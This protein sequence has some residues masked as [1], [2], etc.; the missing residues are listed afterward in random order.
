MSLDSLVAVN[1]TAE[2]SVPTK[3][4]F[5]TGLVL[6]S[7]AAGV[8]DVDERVRT[9]TKASELSEDG[10]SVTGPAY[11]MAALYFGQE[12]KPSKLKVASRLLPP[13]PA[14]TLTIGAVAEDEIV[15]VSVNGT[16]CAHTVTSGQTA[17]D[18]A[19]AL[20]V[21]IEAVTG[22]TSSAASNVITVGV[23]AGEQ[24]H[25][26]DY[27]KHI[28]PKYT[29]TDP[30]V[31]T[32][33]GQILALDDD[34]FGLLLDSNSKAEV[35][36]AAAWAETNRKALFFQ[37][38][39][40]DCFTASNTTNVGYALKAASYA[41][42]M[43]FAYEGN[44]DQWLGAAA[45]G[46]RF[47]AKPGSYS[48]K[49]KTLKG[50]TARKLS[51]SKATIAKGYNLNTYTTVGGLNMVA[52]GV[53]ASGEWMDQT[54]FVEWLRVE[55]QYRTFAKMANEEKVPYTDAGVDSLL[56]I[57]NGALFDGVKAGGLEA[58]TTSS[59]ADPVASIDS[60]IRA[61]R[62][63]PE[64]RFTGKLAGAIHSLTINGTVT[65]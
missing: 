31:A 13:T 63:L 1:I 5:G 47:T 53:S 6:S 27:S 38:S 36:A 9:Y 19:T 30:G 32:D 26:A 62:V 35:V 11:K 60:S 44:T 10:F 24:L 20:E 42:T 15:K 54:I 23:A 50:I 45:M 64:I 14:A 16:E 25:F 28:A 7:E 56:A 2:T 22:V 18:V 46:E 17:A 37:T 43:G 58:G 57:V 59:E 40:A 52:E 33:L 29:T 65:A 34:W 51:A 41:F 8:F 39:D 21:L 12:T 4:G 61:S 49:F 48:F 3:P 55:M